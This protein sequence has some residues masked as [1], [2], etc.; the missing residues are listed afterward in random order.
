MPVVIGVPSMTFGE[1]DPGKST[2]RFV[3]E[4]ANRGMPGYVAGK[5]NV[6]YAGDAARGLVRAIEDGIPGRRYLFTGHNITM[7]DLMTTIAKVTGSA[8]PK[9]IP[10]SVARILASWQSFRYRY[11]KGPVPMISGSAIAVMSYGQF[12]DGRIAE[13]E[14]GYAPTVSVEEAVRRTFRWLCAQGLIA[15]AT[16]TV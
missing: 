13:Q 11:C 8:K 12:L 3:L 10:L 6:V 1:F 16:S 4:M 14:L 15:G 9:E 7:S 2:G 5:R